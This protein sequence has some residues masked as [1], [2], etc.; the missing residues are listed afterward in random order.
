MSDQKESTTRTRPGRKV[1]VSRELRDEI[2]RLR[3]YYGA[4]KIGKRVGLSRKVVRRVLVEEGFPPNKN[5][6][7][8]SK[9]TPFLHQIAERVEKGLTTTRILREVRG[10]GYQGGRT[11]LAEHVRTLRA[12]F[13]LEAP[14]KV[15]RRFETRPGL[16]M[17][18]DWSPYTVIIAGRPTKI[19][20]LGVIL[21]NC[22]KL[23]YAMYRNE[24]QSTLL[25]AMAVAGEY[26]DGFAQRVVIDNMAT[27]VLGR[28]GV[29]GEPIWNQRFIEF[30][31]YYGFT[32]FVCKPRDSDRKGKKE[33]AFR[34]L[35]NDFLKASEFDS[36]EDLEDRL[37]T[38]LDHTPQVCNLRIHGTTG[39]VPNEAYLA[40]RDLLIRLPYDRFPVFEEVVRIV[41]ADATISL[42]GIRYTVPDVLAGRD[43]PVRKYAEHFEVLGPHGQVAYSRRYVDRSVFKGRL[44]IDE[45]CY[46]KRPRRPD[47]GTYGQRLDQAFLRRFPRL[48]PLVE[49]LKLRFKAMANIHV[50]KLLRLSSRYGEQAFVDAALKAQQ[51]RRFKAHSVELILERE[52]PLPPEDLSTPLG[53]LGAIVL[54][55]V[56]EPSLDDG[57]GEL[58]TAPE[59]PFQEEDDHGE[60]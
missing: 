24:R 15:K 52:H 10:L 28:I 8:P 45:S 32:P 21:A 40:E 50:R 2:V 39:L 12:K 25:E 19:H 49:G 51:H 13:G 35:F 36:W 58:D 57:F 59:T 55:E 53:G 37:K 42:D 7:R 31:T 60:Q 33:K 34:L 43:V 5:L 20:A 22:R 38:W 23:H 27:A 44:V 48:L 1:N 16:E 47:N 11:I 4:Q 30:C 41:D 3:E 6:T 17:Q 26:F 46:S 56:D 29:N 18:L 54:G 14:V 9:L